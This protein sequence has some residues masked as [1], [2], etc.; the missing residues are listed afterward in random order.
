MDKYDEIIDRH[1]AE[2]ARTMAALNA[3][4]KMRDRIFFIVAVVLFFV[5]L[6][7]LCDLFNIHLDVEK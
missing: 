1:R 5:L 3:K 2:Q 4:Q 6:Y 7:L